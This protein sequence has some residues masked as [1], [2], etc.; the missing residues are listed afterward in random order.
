VEKYDE[1]RQATDGDTQQALPLT[2]VIR[3]NQGGK[4]FEINILSKIVIILQ[5]PLSDALES[6][7]KVFTCLPVKFEAMF[8]T[9]LVV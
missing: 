6:P 4:N 5:W 7:V 8:I 2:F 1:A 9:T 3:K